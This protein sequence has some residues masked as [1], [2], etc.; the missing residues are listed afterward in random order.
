MNSTYDITI[1][2]FFL[3]I[4]LFFVFSSFF[5]FFFLSL[6]CSFFLLFFLS[7]Y[8]SIFL[9]IFLT[10]FLHSFSSSFFLCNFPFLTFFVSFFLSFSFS[11]FLSS[12]L[13]FFPSVYLSFHLSYLLYYIL[14]LPLTFFLCNFPFLTF[15]SLNNLGDTQFKD[16]SR[17]HFEE[18][19]G[20]LR[21][22]VLYT[23]P[24]VR[25]LDETFEYLRLAVSAKLLSCS[26]LQVCFLLPVMEFLLSSIS[27]VF[28]HF[29]QQIRTE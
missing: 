7:F 16:F 21:E 25:G 9:S 5:P 24:K 29:S 10:Y 6:Y 20:V 28:Y 11:F 27:L 22:L 8:L 13:P 23:T 17:G 12:F 19:M 15:S 3:Y 26:Q 14:P 18:V 2:Y 4:P 1:C